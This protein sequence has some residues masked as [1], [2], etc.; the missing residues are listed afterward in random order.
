LY[1]D[2]S[3]IRDYTPEDNLLSRPVAVTHFRKDEKNLYYINAHHVSGIDNPTCDVVREAITRY[4]PR[5]VVI[6]A[7]TGG[8]VSPAAFLGDVKRLAE[9][10]FRRGG[11]PYYTA[12]LADENNIPFIGGEPIERDVFLAMEKA[13]YSA[14]DMIGSN[15]LRQIPQLRREGTLDEAHF[16]GQATWYLGAIAD[17][18]G[19]SKDAR[20][21][22]D[23]F[24]SWYAEHDKSGKDFLQT[25][26]EDF[27]P[28]NSSDASYFQKL[29]YEVGL[30]RERHIDTVIANSMNEYGTVLVVYG[31]AHLMQSH[32]V[33]EKML[34][35]G[36][37]I[38]ISNNR[39]EKCDPSRPVVTLARRPDMA[40]P[41]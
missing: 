3:L 29:S 18:A 16:S 26:S 36:A 32:A 9:S 39:A 24:K 5:C 22:F 27:A 40:S 19:V 28:F 30:V 33:F 14:K 4:K 7:R 37:T 34:G 21:T 8:E 41:L 20:M 13:G 25:T 38:Q 35:P 10:G 15:L 12:H 31:D 1:A 23:E 2:L 6:E 17:S 11:E